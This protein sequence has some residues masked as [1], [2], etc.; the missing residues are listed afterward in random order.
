MEDEPVGPGW[1]PAET[2]RGCFQVAHLPAA[3]LAW[4]PPTGTPEID[5]EPCF[6]AHLSTNQDLQ[7]DLHLTTP[8]TP[9]SVECVQQGSRIHVPSL[10][11]SELAK[12]EATLI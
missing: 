11:V 7:Q 2:S 9:S 3:N 6:R 12:T 1:R 10:L 8:H 5:G 4:A